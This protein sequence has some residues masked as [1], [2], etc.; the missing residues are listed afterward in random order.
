MQESSLQEEE[1]ARTEKFLIKWPVQF[2]TAQPEIWY[3]KYNSQGPS[4]VSSI[5]PI[6]MNPP[7]MK[8]KQGIKNQI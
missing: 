6:K 4:F 5:F 2:H 8:I 3:F 1:L 7:L